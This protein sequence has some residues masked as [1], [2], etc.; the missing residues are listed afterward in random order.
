MMERAR[1]VH[2]PGPWTVSQPDNGASG[3]HGRCPDMAALLMLSNIDAV[4][5]ASRN[6]VIL[7][8]CFLIS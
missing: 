3:V 8:I 7:L 2:L 5:V 1:K 4:A 6:L